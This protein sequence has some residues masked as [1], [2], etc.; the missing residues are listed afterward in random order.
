[1]TFDCHE[2][3][4]AIAA[5]ALILGLSIAVAGFHLA[6]WL[7]NRDRRRDHTTCDQQLAEAREQV[8]IAGRV[9]AGRYRKENQ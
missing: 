6:E 4:T 9:A 3:A 8:A 2:T 5:G 7:R 1:L